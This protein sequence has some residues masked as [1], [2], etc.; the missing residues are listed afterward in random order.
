MLYSRI[1]HYKEPLSMCDATFKDVFTLHDESSSSKIWFRKVP[2]DFFPSNYYGD[3]MVF[4]I[5]NGV[6]NGITILNS[7]L[8]TQSNCTIWGCP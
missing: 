4:R 7:V 8:V 2:T 1:G 6:T 3:G 5:T